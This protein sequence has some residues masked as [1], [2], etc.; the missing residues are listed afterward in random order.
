MNNLQ[1][2]YESQE[3]SVNAHSVKS[4]EMAEVQSQIFL[5]KQFP[6]N[7]MQ[8]EMKILDAC[9]RLRLAETALYQYPKGGQKVTGPSIRLAETIARYW[10]NINYGIKELEQRNGE[11]TVVAY[12]WDMETNTRQEKVFQVKHQIYT[13][14]GMRSL[15]DPRDI[16]ELAANYGARRLRACILGVIPGDVID[17][18]V[19][20]CARTL[21]TGYQEPLKD[22]LV[23]ALAW[24]KENY[25]ITQEMVEDNFTYKVDS[26]TQQ[27]FLK[28]KTISQSLKDGMAKR[29]D[30]FKVK[31]EKA[32]APKN[33]LEQQFKGGEQNAAEQG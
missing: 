25:G 23:K 7:E 26:F 1:L 32:E 20:Q 17:N 12:A 2:Q 16:Y 33:S 11:S 6:R 5:A 19:E 10:G 15:T 9:K 27:D 14:Q 8:A 4:R 29:E 18:A 31:T 22:R 30:F 24:L 13:K 3:M 28:L 21:E